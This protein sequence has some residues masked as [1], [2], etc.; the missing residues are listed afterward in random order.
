MFWIF[1]VGSIIFAIIGIYQFFRD[2]FDWDD[3]PILIFFG[4]MLFSFFL[5]FY[6][7]MLYTNVNCSLTAVETNNLFVKQY[8]E[9]YK[10]LDDQI[11]NINLKQEQLTVNN[12]TPIS[13]LIEARLDVSNK[14]IKIKNEKNE[15]IR[16]IIER[17]HG[18]FSGVCWCFKQRIEKIKEIK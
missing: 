10:K 13:S 11:K 8:E 3:S 9:E 4:C 18:L 16:N 7:I 12:D 14:L 1:I 17:K 15:H 6:S 2:T 5:A